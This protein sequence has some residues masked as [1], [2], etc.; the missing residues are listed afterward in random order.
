MNAQFDIAHGKQNDV[1]GTAAYKRLRVLDT[2]YK[3]FSSLAQCQMHVLDR[4][5]T[6][7]YAVLSRLDDS[8]SGAYT[9][10][11]MYLRSTLTAW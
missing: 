4:T 2:M 5:S 11:Y 9:G 3:Y 7:T 1:I 10:S 6:G 8:V